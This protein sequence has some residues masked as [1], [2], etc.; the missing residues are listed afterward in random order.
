MVSPGQPEQED[1][2][3]KTEDQAH[4]YKGLRTFQHE[5]G[6]N[7]LVCVASRRHCGDRHRRHHECQKRI[8]KE[9]S[10]QLLQSKPSLECL[11][12]YLLDNEKSKN[13]NKALGNPVRIK[14]R[15][16]VRTDR[17][18]HDR[19]DQ[20]QHKIARKQ[21]KLFVQAESKDGDSEDQFQ[22]KPH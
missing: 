8:A 7:Q 16:M 19:P 18:Q 13:R 1:K 12:E 21:W 9:D 17:G 22:K 15:W 3:E 20:L 10:T 14:I 4:P 6:S 5:N 2:N 11:P